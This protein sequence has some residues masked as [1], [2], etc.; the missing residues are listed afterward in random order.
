MSFI[1]SCLLLK[2][3]LHRNTGV[4]IVNLANNH[5]LDFGSAGINSTLKAIKEHKL[6]LTGL[7]YGEGIYKY[8]VRKIIIFLS[9]NSPKSRDSTKMELT[10]LHEAFI[11]INKVMLLFRAYVDVL[12]FYILYLV[13]FL[14]KFKGCGRFPY[15]FQ[16]LSSMIVSTFRPFHI[17]FN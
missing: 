16:M 12:K 15:L 14:F 6:T 7:T 5:L 9:E 13:N 8:Q 3:L 1:L 10:M 11:V 4:G 17:V 2:F